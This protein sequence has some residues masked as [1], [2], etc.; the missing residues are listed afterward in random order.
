MLSAKK[1]IFNAEELLIE[2]YESGNDRKII[3]FMKENCIRGVQRSM[4]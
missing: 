2:F 4:N 3:E 1:K